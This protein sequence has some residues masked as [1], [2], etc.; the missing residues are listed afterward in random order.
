[1]G[2]IP[3]KSAPILGAHLLTYPSRDFGKCL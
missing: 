1:M 2:E 3:E